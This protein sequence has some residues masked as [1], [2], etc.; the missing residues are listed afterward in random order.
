M[1]LDEAARVASGAARAASL[2][3][4]DTGEA[5]FERAVLA[6][7]LDLEPQGAQADAQRARGALAMPVKTAQRLKDQQAKGS[8]FLIGD[9]L[10]ALDVYWA[11]FAALLAPLP[12]DKCPMM[13]GLRKV[14]E[15]SDPE[16]AKVDPALGGAPGLY[17]QR[18]SGAADGAVDQ[19]EDIIRA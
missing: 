7:F 16:I 15:A 17:L 14:F 8:K 13:E 10:T 2:R 11:T 6:P 5:A 4:A 18:V 12:P 3:G 19:A 1:A 9:S